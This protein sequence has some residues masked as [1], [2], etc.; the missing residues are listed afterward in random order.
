MSLSRRITSY[1]EGRGVQYDT[2]THHPSH[3][4]LGTS[5]AAQVPSRKIAKAVI[6]EDHQGHRLMA[7]I[8]ADSKLS[9]TEL[10][11]QLNGRYHLMREQQ[12]Y[13]CFDD[14]VHGA[15]PPLPG[16][17]NMDSIVDESLNELDDIY[18]EGGDHRNL[19]HLSQADFK[20]LT[21]DARHGRV[22]N[23]MYH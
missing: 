18:L 23:Q 5:I 15:V 1:L 10:N 8:P 21:D 12:V 17:Y 11:E 3:S 9:L 13:E 6:L 16:A 7:V 19:V 22:S 20:R 4:S 14:C 2:V